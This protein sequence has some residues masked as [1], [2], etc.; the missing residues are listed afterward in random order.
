MTIFLSVSIKG[1]SVSNIKEDSLPQLTKI[2]LGEGRQRM[3]SLYHC[4][5]Q[6][7]P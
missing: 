2:I 7:S 5:G 4:E 3:G 6:G 1:G